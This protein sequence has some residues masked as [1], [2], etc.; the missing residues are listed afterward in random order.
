MSAISYFIAT[1][2]LIGAI[3]FMALLWSAGI[4]DDVMR[5]E[6]VREHAG[7]SQGHIICGQGYEDLEDDI[8]MTRAIQLAQNKLYVHLSGSVVKC[9]RLTADGCAVLMDI[10]SGE[11]VTVR[12]C[13]A[14]PDGKIEWTKCLE[15]VAVC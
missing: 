8:I 6:R 13:R 5:E 12:G 3:A 4:S 15:V 1:L 11:L 2:L 7:S 10:N 9:L 14:Y